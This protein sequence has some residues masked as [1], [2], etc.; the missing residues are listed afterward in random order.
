MLKY[1]KSKVIMPVVTLGLLRVFRETG[2]TVFTD[3]QVQK[4]YGA[5]VKMLNLGTTSV[6]GG[7]RIVV[8]KVF[9]IGTILSFLRKN[10]AHSRT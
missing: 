9:G 3:D 4:A 6:F 1:S 2:Q 8:R 10:G 7:L 5:A